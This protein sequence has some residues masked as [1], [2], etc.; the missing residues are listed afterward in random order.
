MAK[1]G[2]LW[3]MGVAYRRMAAARARG[4]SVE[5]L[6]RTQRATLRKRRITNRRKERATSQK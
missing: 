4:T 5:H 3:R 1:T 6:A 2:S